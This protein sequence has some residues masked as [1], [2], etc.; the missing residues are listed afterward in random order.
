M[1]HSRSDQM[2]RLD[3]LLPENFDHV[4]SAIT[5]GVLFTTVADQRDVEKIPRIVRH[6]IHAPQ[7]LLI[8]HRI[9][10]RGQLLVAL[11]IRKS[12]TGVHAG[13]MTCMVRTHVPRPR[14][15]HAESSQRNPVL[16]HLKTSHRIIPALEDIRLTRRL[17]TVAVTTKRMNHDRS[18]RLK[19]T[20]FLRHQSA[21]NKIQIRRRI[22]PSVEPDPHRHLL[23]LTAPLQ[24]LRDLHPVRLRATVDLGIEPQDL[25][26]TPR[27]PWRLTEFQR[28][29]SIPRF[30]Q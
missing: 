25:L 18:L 6:I 11:H 2:W 26:P 23:F 4:F 3:A 9:L 27:H 16:I 29:D 14:S 5:L 30:L 1:P 10:F 17:P 19:L 7:L 13:P 8:P 20:R 22:T 15:S 24:P 12:R 28:L 21:V